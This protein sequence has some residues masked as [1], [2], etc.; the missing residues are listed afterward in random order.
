MPGEDG[1][2]RQRPPFA[3][4]NTAKVW[5][6][7]Y[8]TEVAASSASLLSTLSAVWSTTA[9]ENESLMLIGFPA[10]PARFCQDAD[11]SVRLSPRLS[12]SRSAVPVSYTH[13]TLPTIYSV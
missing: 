10:V 11:A 2:Q 13:L 9:R 7:Q 4:D 3:L 1:A 12:L 6:K 5:L 8:R